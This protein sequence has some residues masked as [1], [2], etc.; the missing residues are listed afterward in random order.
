MS[1]PPAV[2][3]YGDREIELP[4]GRRQRGRAR[5]RHLEAAGADRS[6]HPRQRV[7]EHR[8]VRVGDHVHR[9]RSGHPPLPRHRD[10]RPRQRPEPLVPRDVVAA[11]L[12]R[13]PDPRRARR[14]PLRDPSSHPRARR[15][16]A[17]LRR[18]PEGRPPDGHAVV[19]GHRAEHLLPRQP[20]PQGPRAGP[21]L[22]VAPDGEAADHRRVRVQEVD[23]PAVRVPEQRA[24]PDRELPHDDVLGAVG[25]LRGEPH[26]RQRAQE[27]ADPARRPRAELLHL[28]RPA[29][30]LERGQHLRR[31]RRGHQ[32]ALG[33]AARWRQPEGHRDARGHRGRRRRRRQVR[34]DGQ[35]S[36]T[37]RSSS[38]GSD[39]AST[40][41]TTRVPASSRRRA[42]SCSASSA[43]AITCS[44]SRSSSRP[45][46]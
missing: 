31:D 2:L 36:R 1:E 23:R 21:P 38:P 26:R 32:R 24:R 27:A 16:E 3:R 42:T 10:R 8:V 13:A 5:D 30:R 20:R 44:T 22:D 39:T 33:A 43:V 4:V 25:A 34:E 12:R 18:L 37:T 19:G 46:R 14:V 28:H 35:G 15:R 17:V 29:R 9:R 40:R 6:R 41:T 7:R 45:S 11:H